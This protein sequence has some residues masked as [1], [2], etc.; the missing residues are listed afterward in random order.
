MDPQVVLEF[1]KAV[2]QLVW[3]YT[4]V[5]IIVGHVLINVVA[6]LAAAQKTGELNLSRLA[7]FLYKK[8]LPYVS[9]Y[10]IVKWLGQGAGL[11]MLAAPVWAVIEATLVGDLADNLLTLGLPL[12][13]AVVRYVAKQ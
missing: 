8:L 5:K 12:P 9:V 13:K 10:A 6:A 4:G 2:L 11:D 3:S 7:E 1:A